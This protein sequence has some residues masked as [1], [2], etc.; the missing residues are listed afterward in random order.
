MFFLNRSGECNFCG[1]CCKSLNI[2]TLLS[3]AL[4][5]HR[6]IDEVKLYYHYR[7]IKVIGINEQED[8]LYIEVPIP[9]SQLTP[10]N[11]C[12]IHQDPEKKPLLCHLYPIAKDNIYQCG[13]IFH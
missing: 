13:Y 10:D 12:L 2:T 8:K 4:K 3:H 7:N 5:Q 9:C 6:S 1:E 11:R